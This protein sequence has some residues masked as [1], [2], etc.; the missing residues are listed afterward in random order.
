MCCEQQLWQQNFI[1]A[2]T[3]EN[4]KPNSLIYLTKIDV[5]K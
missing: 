1:E 2:A 3:I 5:Q 4:T